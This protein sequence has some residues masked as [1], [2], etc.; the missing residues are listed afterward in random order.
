MNKYFIR[1]KVTI[2]MLTCVYAESREEACEIAVK[3]PI[4]AELP[5]TPHDGWA[6]PSDC[7]PGV[8]VQSVRELITCVH[9]E[10]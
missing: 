6:L 7:T 1:A 4:P 5:K 10:K 8:D 2:P 9:K 3:L